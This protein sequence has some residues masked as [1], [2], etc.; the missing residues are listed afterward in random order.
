MVEH[1]HDVG[2]DRLLGGDAAFRT[3]MNGAAI[4]VAPELGALLAQRAA[5]RQREDLISARIG[6]HRPR[7]VHESVDAAEFLEDLDT[8]AQQQVIRVGEQH[9]R[10]ARQ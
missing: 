6:E 7:P 9:L 3:Q 1:H 10:A 2:A 5:A 4:D 8:R